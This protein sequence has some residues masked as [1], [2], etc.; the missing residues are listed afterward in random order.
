MQSDEELL[1]EEAPDAPGAEEW[2]RK[3]K[4]EFKKR[5]GANWARVLYAKAWILYGKDAKN[6]DRAK[7]EAS[8]IT[9]TIAG[10]VG[11]GK[12]AIARVMQQTLAGGGLDVQFDD[13]NEEA[14]AEEASGLGD[15]SAKRVVISTVY[16]RTPLGEASRSFVPPQAVRDAARLGL[17]LRKKHNR[18]GW[19]SRQAGA[20]GIGSGVVRAQTLA[21]G[22]GVSPDTVRRMHSFFQRH[23]GKV[24][25]AARERDETSAA[26][27][28]WLLW[29]G[30]PGR[31]WVA[32]LLGKDRPGS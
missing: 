15:V 7:M 16:D 10:P 4:T 5:Y 14:D 2:I 13:A 29:G 32:E 25:R 6:A 24:E 22:R 20:A 31:K 19:D 28:A 21:A 23:D 12:S 9:V 17:E 18:G 27:I 1:R 26:N 3:H 30:D 8:H 11:A